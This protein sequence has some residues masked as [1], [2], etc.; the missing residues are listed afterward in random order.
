MDRI[1]PSARLEAQIAELLSDGLS[2]DAEKLAELGRLGA[3]M[4]LQ[5]AIDE[6]V[7]AFLGRARY[8][9]TPEAIGS[10][11][12]TRARPIQTAEGEIT[13]AVPRSAMPPSPSSATCFLIAAPLSERDRWRR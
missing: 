3:R 6:E 12:G 10:R 1:A 11:N 13:I 2:A 4:V 9:R 5:R 7:E 8:E